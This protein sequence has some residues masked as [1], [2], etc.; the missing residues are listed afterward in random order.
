MIL[1]KNVVPRVFRFSVAAENRNGDVKYY[2][3]RVQAESAAAA[4]LLLESEFEKSG[5]RVVRCV[6]AESE[7]GKEVE[8]RETGKSGNAPC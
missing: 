8:E 7:A 4:A 6:C 1:R 5:L 3:C 2:L